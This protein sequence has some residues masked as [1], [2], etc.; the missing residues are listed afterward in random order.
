M[1]IVRKVLSPMAFHVKTVRAAM[2][3]AWGNPT[4]LKFRDIGE[5][6]DNLFVAEFA[7][8]MEMDRVL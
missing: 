7:G 1:T 8:K 3:P 6:G 4:G 5:K 2:K